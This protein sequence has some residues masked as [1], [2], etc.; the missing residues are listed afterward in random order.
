MFMLNHLLYF[1]NS[2]NY[3]IWNQFFQNY[4]SQELIDLY[5]PKYNLQLNKEKLHVIQ[6]FVS[7]D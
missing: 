2:L 1:F 7:Y 3:H 6:I 5:F 4:L